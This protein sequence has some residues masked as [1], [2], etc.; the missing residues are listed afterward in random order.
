MTVSTYSEL[1]TAIADWMARSDISASASDFITFG[2]ARLNRSINPVATTANLTGTIGTSV[3]SVASL[4]IVSPVSLYGED[5]GDERLI[6]QQANGTFTIEDEDGFPD[7]WALEGG[8]I[9]FDCP[10]AEA[11]SFRFVY[12]GKLALSDVSPTNSFLIDF[13]DVY[14]AAA[15]YWGCVYTQNMQSAGNWKAILDE[16]LFEAKST[17]AQS[18]RGTL[19]VDPMLLSSGGSYNVRSDE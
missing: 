11:Y 18:K 3:L 14:L 6:L 4:G 7:I 9:I 8:N 1:K 2:E 16:G 10:L 15:I 19:S 5:G 13:P 12:K 17:I